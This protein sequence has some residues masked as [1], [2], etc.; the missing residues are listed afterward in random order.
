MILLG[1]S[2][3]AVWC[4]SWFVAKNLKRDILTSNLVAILVTPPIL[5]VLPWSIVKQL[6]AVRVESATFLFFSCILS[7]VLLLSHV[8]AL[9][10]IWKGT[11]ITGSEPSSSI[12]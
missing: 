3:A 10:D 6:V 5:W 12:M 11:K 9:R 4:I 7:A 2:Y 1:P 8:D